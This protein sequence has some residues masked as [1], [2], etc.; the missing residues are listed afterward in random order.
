MNDHDTMVE[1]GERP[2]PE[3][4]FDPARGDDEADTSSLIDDVSALF[5][6]GKTYAQAELAFQK[7]RARYLGGSV[8]GLAVYA[9]GAIAAFH[10]ALIAL[11]V[12]LVF[13]LASAIGPWLATLVVT[14]VYLIIAAILALS[15]KR[16]LGAMRSALTD[17]S[18][19]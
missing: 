3:P 10:L 8:K 6:D 13:A 17:R 14:L 18:N 2:I 12:G 16:R 9:G 19:A 5:E 1:N 7:S 11:T 4:H 15:L